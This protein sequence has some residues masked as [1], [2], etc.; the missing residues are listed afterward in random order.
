[1]KTE[2]SQGSTCN[3]PGATLGTGDT[4]VRNRKN[5]HANSS[6]MKGPKCNDRE[7]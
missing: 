3:V 1:M 5:G 2:I 7:V 6:A 4:R